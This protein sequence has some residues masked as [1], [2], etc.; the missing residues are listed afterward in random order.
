[1]K[2]WNQKLPETSILL[3]LRHDKK[4]SLQ[5]IADLYGVSRERVRQ[6]IGNTGK[7]FLY[8]NIK[9]PNNPE[10]MTRQS[11]LET[12]ENG[13]GKKNIIQ[14]L[15]KI[16]HKINHGSSAGSGNEAEFIISK[17]LNSDGILNSCMP[18][19]NPFDI[20]L[21]NGLRVDVKS[22]KIK[23]SADPKRKTPMYKFGVKKDTRG[24]YCD[25]FICYIFETQDFFV[26]PNQAIGMVESLYIG[27]PKSDRSW[28]TWHQYHN[29]LD[30]LRQ[31]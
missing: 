14:L 1:M 23:W 9:L 17:M 3:S 25:F 27:W 20:L 8:K 19:N 31:K 4:M 26:I 5:E 22:T 30:L 7:D 18:L 12:L 24:D 6:K 10:E 13:R 28:S 15:S 11:V 16:H 21:D 29:R 2:Y